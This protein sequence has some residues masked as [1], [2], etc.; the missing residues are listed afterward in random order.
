MTW[1]GQRLEASVSGTTGRARNAGYP[2]AYPMASRC[3]RLLACSLGARQSLGA[4]TISRTSRS[5]TAGVGGVA[6]EKSQGIDRENIGGQRGGWL[7]VA[8]IKLSA[9]LPCTY[10]CGA[11]TGEL[12]GGGS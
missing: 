1:L 7:P 2:V 11:P 8:L 12:E 9:S 3:L 5:L 6:R 4:R 10:I